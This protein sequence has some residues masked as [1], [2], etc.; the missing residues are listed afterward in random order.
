MST[1][2]ELCA[3]LH[4]ET[5]DSGSFPATVIGVTGEHARTVRWVRNA[6]RELQNR[7]QDWL[8]LRSRWTV[9]TTSGD[10]E[11]AYGD[12][13]DSRLTGA[14]SR[15]SR[16][17]L[18]DIE[19]FPNVKSYLTSAGVSGEK[20][21]IPLSWPAFRDLYKKGT[22]T[23]NAPV[24]VSVDPQRN[25]VFGPKPNGI[26]TITGEYQMSAQVLSLDADTPEMPVDYHMLIVYLAMKKYGAN[27][28]APEVLSRGITEGNALLRQIEGNQRPECGM[29]GSLA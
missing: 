13:T 17:W 26:Y 24:H 5:I 15:F 21:L 10:D 25:L 6:Y 18:Y 27:R 14:I 20:Y 2:Q 16:W 8:W 28:S 29:A 4:G 1:F 12:V 11:Y 9:D 3:E 23:N 22:Q 19:G 7:H